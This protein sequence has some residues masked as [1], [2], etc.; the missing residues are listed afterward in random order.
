MSSAFQL[1]SAYR[2][3]RLAAHRDVTTMA[4]GS[5]TRT[6]ATRSLPHQR[7]ANEAVSRTSSVRTGSAP[8]QGLER[9]G[10]QDSQQK[11]MHE[12]QCEPET[13]H[14]PHR[15]NADWATK[16]PCAGVDRQHA[17]RTVAAVWTSGCWLGLHRGPVPGASVGRYGQ[18]PT[19]SRV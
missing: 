14:Q 9:R 4:A 3:Y 17:G 7:R 1:S 13:G 10:D 16:L 18:W 8:N 5:A 2:P 19:P 6:A 11:E 12:P 15:D